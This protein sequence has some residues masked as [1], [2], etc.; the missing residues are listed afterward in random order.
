MKIFYEDKSSSRILELSMKISDDY[1][2]EIK[3]LEQSVDISIMAEDTSENNIVLEEAVKN[4][5]G[6]GLYYPD[7]TS[8]DQNYIAVQCPKII[9]LDPNSTL[10]EF[11]NQFGR[12]VFDE[13]EYKEAVSKLVYYVFYID[14]S[15]FE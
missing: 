9:L 4:W 12:V 7:M 13:K 5:A 8:I 14:E 10:V 11:F 6:Y 2:N 3:K 15:E 1:K